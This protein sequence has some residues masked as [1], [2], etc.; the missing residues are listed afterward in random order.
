[1]RYLSRK[2]LSLPLAIAVIL[3]LA[4]LLLPVAAPR[5]L[6]GSP[7]RT[8]GEWSDTRGP[9]DGGA[10]D[11]ELSP[12]GVLY[13]SFGRRGIWQYENDAWSDITEGILESNDYNVW[14][15]D[16]AYAGTGNILYAATSHRNLGGS[17]WKYQDGA[18]EDIGL[19]DFINCDY[20]LAMCLCYDSNNDILYAGVL[21]EYRNPSLVTYGRIFKYQHGVWHTVGS[22]LRERWPES[23]AYN[24]SDNILYAG[25]GRN[26]APQVGEVWK[27]A[28]GMWEDMEWP[29][30]EGFTRPY[31]LEYVHAS[32]VLYVGSENHG[33]WKYQNGSWSDT[34]GEVAESQISSLEYDSNNGILYAGAAGSGRWGIWKYEYGSWSPAAEE[35]STFYIS[36]ICYDPNGDILYAGTRENSV[37]KYSQGSWVNLRGGMSNYYVYSL[38]YDSNNSVLYAG[39]GYYQHY[40]CEGVFKYKNGEWSN[41]GGGIESYQVYSLEYDDKN[42]V[43]YAAGRD[44]ENHLGGVWKY[45]SGVWIN[46]WEEFGRFTPCSLVYDG[47][48]D[49]LY[50][51]VE[52]N[53]VWKYQNEQWESTG[54]DISNFSVI[55]FVYDDIHEI[56]Y[57]GTG[58][59]WKYE[60]G[61]WEDTGGGGA[62]QYV[63]GLA[64]DRNHDILYA[65][66][67]AGEIGVHK[68][69]DGE[70]TYIGGDITWSK[71]V[72]EL[73]YD[74]SHDILYATKDGVMFGGGVY[75]YEKGEWSNTGGRVEKFVVQSLAY[76]EANNILYAGTGMHDL[77]RFGV[78]KY[79]LDPCI[80]EVDPDSG[81]QGD[82]LNV[83]ITGENTCFEDGVS[84]AYF[85]EGI[86]VDNP[87][88]VDSPT[89]ATAHITIASDAVMGLRDVVVTTGESVVKGE[90]FFEVMPLVITEVAPGSGAQGETL[91]VTITGEN[92]C[93]EDGVSV[94]DFGEGIT[95]NGTTVPDPLDP[96]RAEANIT[97]AFNA[98]PGPR[99]VVVTTG[100][101]VAKG[102]GIFEVVLGAPSGRIDGTWS[103]TFISDSGAEHDLTWYIEETS[104][105]ILSVDTVTTANRGEADEFTIKL[106]DQPGGSLPGTY[107]PGTGEIKLW[108]SLVMHT[109]FYGLPCMHVVWANIGTVDDPANPSVI[110]CEDVKVE[111]VTPMGPSTL[112]SGSSTLYRQE[113]SLGTRGYS[114]LEGL[115]RG[116]VQSEVFDEGQYALS[117]DAD[118]DSVNDRF[119]LKDVVLE[120]TCG[121][122]NAI[123]EFPHVEAERD[124]DEVQF[125]LSM[126]WGTFGIDFVMSG[127]L[128]EDN[129]RVAGEYYVRFPTLKSGTFL[130]NVGMKL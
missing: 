87:I 93:F 26:P 102:E 89:Q 66:T 60:N 105:G 111:A 68:Y 83:T 125:V 49:I 30:T 31:A 5:S 80:I 130:R 62:I 23:L 57:A 119:I 78:W 56:L 84:V 96:I 77:S 16:L 24:S 40:S 73:V 76:D 39:A 25:F 106:F 1:M 100:S 74:A 44:Y 103:G 90:R 123:M 21:L 32:D 64:Y 117:F 59:V 7:T 128:N 48:H 72:T 4:L 110:T 47:E 46:I 55:S 63:D 27:Y 18:W 9:G 53:G 82:T 91:D 52:G 15:G 120:Q 71:G 95:V 112:D 86:T 29:F 35:L 37:W 69:E 109:V 113:R 51:G 114:S 70:W 121:C 94:A 19:A 22:P 43:L 104:L 99:D 58:G 98:S 115:W 107:D 65:G 127:A 67:C 13:R 97:I 38:E 61:L 122:H 36:S 33:V 10:L 2:Q 11:L 14:V 85:G 79:T 6:S 3:M 42:D 50:A 129:T 108:T 28:N 54:G 92:T 81:K 45:Q 20:R 41:T 75:K 124:L 12:E 126:G 116:G 34:G 88:A 17:V 101:S 118:G 8:S